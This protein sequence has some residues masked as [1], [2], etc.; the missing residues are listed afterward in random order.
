MGVSIRYPAR[1]YR[2]VGLTWIASRRK[3]VLLDNTCSVCDFLDMTSI[4]PAKLDALRAKIVLSDLVKLKVDL[5]PSGKEWKG[6]CPFHEETVPS[7]TVNN[8][9]GFYHCFGCGA[10]GDAIRWITETEQKTF[11]EAVT[12]LASIVGIELDKG[13]QQMSGANR[14]GGAKLSR[15]ETVTVRLDPKLNYLCELAARAQRRTK[16]SFVEWAV[17]NA[18]NAVEL[19]ET[20]EYD[21]DF[22]NIRPVTVA[23]KSSELWQVD[24]P[25]R[26]V[27]LAMI[28]PALL[29]H[30]EQIIWK[31]V[32]ESGYLWRGAYNHS[33]EWSW[34]LDMNTLIKD[35][36]RDQWDI[37]KSV[38]S[39][40][41]PKE[42]LPSWIKQK[43]ADDL[44]DDIVF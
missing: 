31:H 30:D 5:S 32:K 39:G 24:E 15:S 43:T 3:I 27:A 12:V 20:S 25:D 19:P 21:S 34:E 14:K 42:K 8:D 38:A 16:S 36:L 13:P 4:T 18:L 44:D 9:K 2:S 10:H 22:G 28:A 35:R 37:F 17:A 6:L 7:F 40:D 29:N 1:N 33:G 26:L 11:F 23:D 41:L